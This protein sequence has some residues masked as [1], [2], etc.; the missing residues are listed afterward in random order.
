MKAQFWSFD[1]IFAI[2]IFVLAMVIMTY[3]WVNINNE[4]SL[5]YSSNIQHM[6]SQLV[7][8]GAQ[9]MSTGY[10]PNWEYTSSVTNTME[11]ANISIGLGNGTADGLSYNKMTAL[12]F[13]SKY[14]YQE[15]KPPLG[16]AYDYYITITGEGI[17]YA[18]GLNPSTENITSIQVEKFPAVLNGRPVT[19]Q[20]E[21]WS[22]STLGIE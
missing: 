19:V 9:L 3:I 2:I 4:F 7:E 13:L 11:W 8:T 10:P 6:Q 17:N 20:L 1:L 18:A 5:A 16:L 14:D 22:N 12:R 21:I 15:T